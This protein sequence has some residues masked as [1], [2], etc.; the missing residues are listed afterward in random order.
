MEAVWLNA[1]FR[2]CIMCTVQEADGETVQVTDVGGQTV[3]DIAPLAGRLVLMLSG[4][5]DHAVLPCHAERVAISA[6]CQ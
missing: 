1:V 6:W 3:V 2:L 4:A 5:V